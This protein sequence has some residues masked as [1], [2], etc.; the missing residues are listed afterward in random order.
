MDC[1]PCEVLRRK[2][3]TLRSKHIAAMQCVTSLMLV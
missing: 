2:L 1:D 3:Y